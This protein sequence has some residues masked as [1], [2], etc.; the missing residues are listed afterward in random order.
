MMNERYPEKKI[1]CEIF[2]DSM[3][4]YKKYAIPPA[5]GSHGSGTA[6]RSPKYTRHRNQ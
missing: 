5:I 1:K 2:R 3:Q 4:N 6:K